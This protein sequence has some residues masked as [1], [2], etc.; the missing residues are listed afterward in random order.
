MKPGLTVPPA[1]SV[2]TAA[3]VKTATSVKTA[4]SVKVATSVKAAPSMKAAALSEVDMVHMMEVMKTI[5]ED[6]R[7]AEAERHR[8]PIKPRVVIGIVRIRGRGGNVTHIDARVLLLDLPGA[9]GLFA[10]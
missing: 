10:R 4:S 6:E 5:D 8:G 1:S 3:S 7:R 9:V 2:K